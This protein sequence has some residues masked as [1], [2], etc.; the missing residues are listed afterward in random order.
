MVFNN[1]VGLPLCVSALVFVTGVFATNVQA[2]TTPSA[3][4]CEQYSEL[5]DYGI[6]GEN[7]FNYGNNS[8]INDN[9]IDGSGNTPTPVGQV[10][11]VDLQFPPLSPT[12]FP[13]A[14]TGGA[15]LSN[16]TNIAPGSYGTISTSK[17]RGA[18]PFVSFSGGGTYYIEELIFDGRD[19]EAQLGPGDYFIERLD[20]DNN[21]YLN[22]VP[23]GRVRLYVR[24]YIIGDNNIFVNS[25]G[26]VS[27]ML[28]YLYD[29]AYVDLGNFNEGG[30]SNTVINFNGLIYSP[31]ASTS[32]T[33]GNNN[34]YQGAILTPG[35]VNVGNN[36]SFNYSPEV[37]DELIDAVGCSPQA[38]IHHLRIRHP[39]SIVSCY[40]AVVEVLAC[41]DASCSQLYTDSVAVDLTA[42]ASGPT[43][44][45]GNV[46]SSSGANATLNF[47]N[48]SGVAG[49]Q[50]ISGGTATLSANGSSPAPAAATQ[51]VDSSGTVATNC[52]VEFSTAGLI[53]A[54]A[55]GQSTI[56]AS[57]AGVDFSTTLRAVQTNTTTGACEARLSGTQAVEL[58]VEC[59]NPTQCQ[60]GQSYT[61]NGNAIPLNDAGA[62]LSYSTQ[63]LNFDSTGTAQ[64]TNNYS[65]V[66]LLRM[67][68]RINLSSSPNSNP[69]VNDPSLTLTGTSLNDY[70]VK[71]HTLTV[72][73][74]DS[75]GQPTPATTATGAGYTAAG[76][77]FAAVVRSFNAN[78]QVT[79]N[80]GN[81]VTP[82]GVSVSF[83]SVAYPLPSHP[84]ADASKLVVDSPFIPSTTLQGA[85]VS[86]DVKWNEAGTVNLQAA[87]PSDSYLGGGDAFT[88]PP[89]A[90]GRFYPAYFS[91]LTGSVTN[92]CSAGDFSYMGDAAALLDATI[93][94]RSVDGFRLYN[95]GENYNGTA[96]LTSVARNTPADTSTD[97]FISRWQA[98][99]PTTWVE[100][101]LLIASTDATLQKRSDVA[102]DGPFAA[103]DIGL[104]VASEIDSRDFASAQKTLTTLSGDAVPLS[105]QLNMVYGRLALD[106]TYGPE[107]ANLPV[108]LRAEYWNGDL[109]ATHAADQ[110]TGYA[111]SELAVVDYIDPITTSA[112][113]AP[114]TLVEGSVGTSPLFWTIP[115]GTPAQGEFRFEL[116]VPSFLEYPWQDA[117]G[118]T[119]TNPRAYGGFGEYRG[120]VRKAT[121]Q[122]LTQ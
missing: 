6:V 62:A 101:Q 90:I 104:Q 28:V 100:G 71:P 63:V 4:E 88:R 91:L 19:S 122:D 93:E 58:A 86:N 113:G 70:V 9:Q 64:L 97:E 115:T 98:T 51:C 15:D 81:E 110:C 57:F 12:S 65:D 60:A 85:Y 20:L 8:E 46:V 95:Y 45:G 22:I 117:D 55:D 120:N 87:L 41:A 73:A 68:A 10:D 78:G 3:T 108:A 92:S 109:F 74:L 53:V 96:V 67:S 18:T 27:D 36:T 75:A 83:D 29:N 69:A 16:A 40:S 2:Q 103:M 121:E 30:A 35:T 34:N 26:P 14:Q 102:P 79:P 43:W 31:F 80:F 1:R 7:G 66:G 111:P 107:T 37:Q 77:S 56:P 42:G 38:S 32:V 39:Q 23:Q 119:F 61:V 33:L 116:D 105:N 106:N 89:S 25:S 24:D 54:A 114:G 112:G 13:S 11:T 49:L 48:G 118:T 72:Q 5:F 94:A 21:S 17:Q 82:L 59:S 99:L 84:N 52:A 47:S 44:Q 50:W 76:E